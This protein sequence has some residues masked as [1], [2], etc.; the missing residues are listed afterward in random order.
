[1]TSAKTIRHIRTLHAQG[2]SVADIHL[3]TGV[4]ADTIRGILT[5][6]VGTAPVS[7][8]CEHP[9]PWT[10]CLTPHVKGQRS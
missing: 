3:T 7:S 1:M 10:H 6:P 4:C 5:V 9:I 8:P 2:C